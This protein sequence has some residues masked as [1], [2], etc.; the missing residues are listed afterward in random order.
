MMK[1]SFLLILL[2]VMS[3]GLLGPHRI[4]AAPPG[5]DGKLRIIVF[6]AHPDDAEF[7]AGGSAALWA[8]MGHHVKFVSVTNGDLGHYE[9]GG[10]PLARRRKK[11][12][13]KAAE[14]LGITTQVLDIHDGELLPTL[15]NRKTLVRLIRDW[16]ADIVMGHPGP[17]ITAPIIATWAS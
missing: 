6:G 3:A 16:Q 14:I 1:R 4:N 8:S 12:V 13:L 9:M 2:T 15:E 17:M 5:D 11:E 7:D 10:G